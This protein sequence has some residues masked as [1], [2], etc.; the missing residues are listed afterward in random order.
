MKKDQLLL[1]LFILSLLKILLGTP[2]SNIQFLQCE[3]TPARAEFPETPAIFPETPTINC[4]I[5]EKYDSCIFEHMNPCD[6]GLS[7]SN[8]WNKVK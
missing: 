6:V 7:T 4:S 3:L 8:P 1:I 2:P 5:D